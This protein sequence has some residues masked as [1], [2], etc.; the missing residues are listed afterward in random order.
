M[1]I[2]GG[3]VRLPGF[4]L[5]LDEYENL[6]PEVDAAQEDVDMYKLKDDT[7]LSRRRRGTPPWS[8]TT[9]TA[10]FLRRSAH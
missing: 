3:I 9:R 5:H 4:Q 1:S 8:S 2:F 7:P 6:D 10:T